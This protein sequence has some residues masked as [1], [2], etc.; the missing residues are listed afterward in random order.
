MVAGQKIMPELVPG[1]DSN[2]LVVAVVV[3]LAVLAVVLAP[4]LASGLIRVG[5]AVAIAVVVGWI[6]VT[7]I[8]SSLPD[9]A[10]TAAGETAI[11]DLIS[12]IVRTLQPM[13][14]A[15]AIIGIGTAAGAFIL[16]RGVV[17]VRE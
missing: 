16:D 13:A 10:A 4:T 5:I 2:L 7:L 9:V 1:L 11:A 3:V 6:G 8:S 15:L 17:T 12:A 14:A